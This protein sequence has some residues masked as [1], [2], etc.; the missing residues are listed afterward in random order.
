MLDDDFYFKKWIAMNKPNIDP[1]G[2]ILP[3]VIYTLHE[4]GRRLRLGKAAFRAARKKGLKVR[5]SGRNAY[6]LGSDVIDYLV[7]SASLDRTGS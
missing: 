2:E 4:A 5:Y 6:V 7:H 3:D 1:P